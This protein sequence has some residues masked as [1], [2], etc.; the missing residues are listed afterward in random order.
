[1]ARHARLLARQHELWVLSVEEDPDL[2]KQGFDLVESR[3]DG[4][5]SI[6]CYFAS[7]KN[8]LP[9]AWSRARAW[10]KVIRAYRRRAPR[11]DLIHAHVLLDAGIVAAGLGLRW[12][13]PF[14]VTE[15]STAYW[16]EHPL[17]GIR[18]PLA[19]WAARRAAALLPVT[20]A[21]GRAMQ[22]HG[23][24]GRYGSVSNVVNARLYR[25]SPPPAYPP[26]TFL[27]VSNFRDWHKNISGLLRA[28]RDF[29]LTNE[30]ASTLHLAGDGDRAELDRLIERT[31]GSEQPA[32]LTVSGP[33]PETEIAELLAKSHAFVL[34]SHQEN[35][36]VV[37]LEAL[38]AGRPAVATTVG[39]IPD[40]ID[41]Q[42]GRLVAPGD[43]AALTAALGEIVD[44]Y[45]EFDRPAIASRASAIFGEAAVLEAL[46]TAY[47]EALA[48]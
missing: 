26:F 15:H 24:Q 1:M 16:G 32:W 47:R 10:W 14:V 35:Q 3:R 44:H 9:A 31:L 17:P 11:P 25:F 12:Q 39:G 20:P 13:I 22:G 37:L 7:P 5:Q 36:P 2:K 43:E 18:G 48:T 8:G 38:C 27:H 33:H 46:Q 34:F 4:Y 45:G 40:L 21:L 30:V 23:L 28:F 41:E 19:R 29:I 6:V 42:N